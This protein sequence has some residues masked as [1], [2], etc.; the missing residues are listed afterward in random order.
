MRKATE[1]T[2]EEKLRILTAKNYWELATPDDIPTLKMSDGPNGVRVFE[3]SAGWDGAIIPSTCYPSIATLSCSWNEEL[4]YLEGKCIAD[5]MI[6]KGRD[7]LLAP[8][9]NIKRTPLCGRNFEYFS[10]DAFFTGVMAKSYIK[11]V[12]DKGVGAC[13]KHFCANNREHDRANVSSNLDER[14]LHET[15]LKAFSMA[16][17]VEPWAVMCSYNKLNGVYTVE[18]KKLLT[19]TLRNKMGYKGVTMSDWGGGHNRYKALRAG[20]DL[21]MPYHETAYDEL[22]TAYDKGLISDKEINES[23]QRLLDLIE[24]N[25]Q[26]KKIRRVEF[27]VEQKHDIATKIAKESMVLLKNDGILPLRKINKMS[28]HGR[29]SFLPAHSGGGSAEVQSTFIQK[30]LHELLGE[31]MPSTQIKFWDAFRCDECRGYTRSSFL[32]V[33]ARESY[34]DDAIVIV[35]GT[36]RMEEIEGKDRDTLKIQRGYVNYINCVAKYNQG[37]VIVVLEAN[38]AIDV[39]D[40]IDNISALLYTGFAGE[41]MNEAIADILVGNTNPSGKL[42]ETFPISLDDCFVSLDHNIDFYDDYTDGVFVGYRHFDKK[43]L[44][45]RYPFGYGLSYSTFEYSNLKVE[46]TG[47]TN[48]TLSFIITNTSS[49]DGKEIAEIYMSDTFSLLERPKKELVAFKKVELNAL[50]SK[51]IKIDID[52]KAFEYYLPP[53]DGFY[54]ENGEY[55]VQVGASSKDIRLSQ[56]ININLDD[57]TQLSVW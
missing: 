14:T 2:I 46:K 21:K 34:Y 49:V 5:D 43:G 1:F 47:E 54:L 18:N 20:L 44:P 39:S 4:A 56:K 22:K 11:G 45:V 25:E 35:V 6:E 19:E 40:F 27:T 41:G 48:F 52:S 36:D 29:F 51:E 15:Y 3:E 57:D 13:V 37:K 10:E 42:T 12:Q 23:V 26:A 33:G 50:E 16:F 28:V 7:L 30:S 17:E 38:S 32:S 53:I 24:K 55:E 8:G 31:K 9:V